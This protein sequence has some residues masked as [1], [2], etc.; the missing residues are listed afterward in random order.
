MDIDELASHKFLQIGIG[1]LIPDLCKI[2]KTCIGWRIP[3]SQIAKSESSLLSQGG[4]ESRFSLISHSSVIQTQKIVI[5]STE[6]TKKMRQY[7][8]ISQQK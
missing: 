7:A 4:L 1:L 5:L 3:T 6:N 2:Y 8:G